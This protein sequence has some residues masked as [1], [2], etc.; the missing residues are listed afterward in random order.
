MIVAP[1]PRKGY[2][3]SDTS[4]TNIWGGILMP[5]GS[6]YEP[7]RRSLKATRWWTS[8]CAGDEVDRDREYLDA[9]RLAMENI[10]RSASAKSKEI[11]TTNRRVS[12]L[13]AVICHNCSHKQSRA[14]AHR[15]H[16]QVTRLG[17]HAYR[18]TLCKEAA[19]GETLPFVC[20]GLLLLQTV[21]HTIPRTL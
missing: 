17:G 18:L 11:D 16:C 1:M 19:T 20:A 7:R 12:F 8:R 3:W 13:R 15:R 14:Q 2:P 10:R 21:V 6:A 4:W 9:V 5:R